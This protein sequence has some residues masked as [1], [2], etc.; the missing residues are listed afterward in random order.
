[1][2]TVPQAAAATV[3]LLLPRQR[4]RRNRR[5]LAMV[6]LAFAAVAHYMHARTVLVF[7]SANPGATVHHILSGGGAVVFI[8]ADLLSFLSL[9]VGAH[10]DDA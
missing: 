1:M 4:H 5:Y 10:E 9:L 3:G 8:A 2:L 6:A 7:V